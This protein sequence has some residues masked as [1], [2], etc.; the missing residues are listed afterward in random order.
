M[1]FE[2]PAPRRWSAIS[3]AR[4][5]DRLAPLLETLDALPRIGPAL[6]K[7]FFDAEWRNMM[8]ETSA[9]LAVLLNEPE[10]VPILDAIEAAAKPFTT[11]VIVADA[12]MAF[13]T[14]T[15]IA[16]SAALDAIQTFLDEAAISP[17]A[18]V[19]A[20]I[21]RAIEGREKFGKGRH[22]AALNFGDCLSYGAARYY[23]STQ[24]FK[25][26]DFAQTDVN[27]AVRR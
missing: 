5:A 11:A 10:R 17:V 15:G 19:P 26:D 3:T 1:L 20:M 14:R 4:G 21:E 9:V 12:A 18:F 7:A 8:I 24:L 27:D 13:A 2:K 22:P 23:R 25:G 6:D 16:P